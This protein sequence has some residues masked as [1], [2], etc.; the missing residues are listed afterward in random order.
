MF[1]FGAVTNN[2]SNQKAYFDRLR[3]HYQKEAWFKS[4]EER[5]KQKTPKQRKLDEELYDICYDAI[6]EDGDEKWNKAVDCVD[7]VF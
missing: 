6:Y 3:E 5:D 2:F 7:A 4:A 1:I